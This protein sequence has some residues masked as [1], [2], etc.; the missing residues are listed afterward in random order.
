M[1]RI[2]IRHLDALCKLLN[3][4]TDSPRESWSKGA[5][6]HYRA[7]IGNYH[8]SQAYGGY[9]LHRMMTDGG[10]V[11]TPLSSGHI[12]ARELYGMMR[13][14]MDGIEVGRKP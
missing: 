7:N 13:A 11:T 6:G 4:M 10:G 1:E 8:I 2:T 5:D 12:P 14:Y 9:C 3:E